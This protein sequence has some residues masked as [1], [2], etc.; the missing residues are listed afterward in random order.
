MRPKRHPGCLR[1]A[2][3]PRPV[4]CVHAT[5]REPAHIGSGVDRARRPLAVDV[6]WWQGR[7]CLIDFPQATDLLL[8]PQGFDLLYRYVVRICEWFRRKGLECETDEIFAEL[9]GAA[10]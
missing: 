10:W 6:L 5:G 9:L 7:I 8:N 2:D 4:R 3:G 1:P